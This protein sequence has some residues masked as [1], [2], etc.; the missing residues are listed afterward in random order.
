MIYFYVVTQNLRE[1]TVMIRTAATF[2]RYDTGG[3][4]LILNK[5]FIENYI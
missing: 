1:P 5:A 2:L 4:G 3:L